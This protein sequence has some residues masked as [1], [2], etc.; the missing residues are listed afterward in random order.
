MRS[1]RFGR[2]FA[3]AA[4]AAI[5]LASA[6]TIDAQAVISGR[7]TGDQGQPLG[8]ANVYIQELGVGGATTAAGNYVL[9]MLLLSLTGT[10][11]LYYGDEIGM[12]DNMFLGDRNGVRTPMHWSSDKNAGFSRASPQALVY[13]VI[14]DPEYHYESSNVEAQERNVNSLLW[15]NKRVLALQAR[16]E[17]QAE[18]QVLQVASKTWRAL[19]LLG[20]RCCLTAKTAR[21]PRRASSR[22]PRSQ[23]LM[24]SQ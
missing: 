6:T 9:N 23:R 24:T 22:Y 21:P 18:G 2:A 3:R 20:R 4:A 12:G 10:P 5:C 17:S 14:I 19:A 13:P 1:I 15:W 8:G 7:V 11:V 16:A